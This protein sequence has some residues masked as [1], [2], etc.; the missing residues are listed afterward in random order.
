RALIYLLTD[1]PPRS[2]LFP[3]T[4]LFRSGGEQFL[5]G[6]V[7]AGED[8]RARGRAQDRGVGDERDAAGLGGVDDVGVLGQSLSH[9]AAGDEEQLVD[10]GQRLAQGRRIGVVRDTDLHPVGGQVCGLRRVAHDGDNV[11]CGDSAG[12]EGGDGRAAEVAGGAG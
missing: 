3:Y 4:T 1:G 7:F 8:Q 10:T 6:L 5:G 12:A 2:T 11:A 9:F